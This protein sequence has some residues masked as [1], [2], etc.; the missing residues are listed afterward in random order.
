MPSLKWLKLKFIYSFFFFFFFFQKKAETIRDLQER[1]QQQQEQT[2]RLSTGRRSLSSSS[3]SVHS[4]DGIQRELELLRGEKDRQD[5]ET[6]I[7]QRSLEELSSRLEAQQQAI[8]AKDETI[9]QLMEMIQSNKGLESKQLEMH[10]EQHNADKKKLAE[11]LNQ[12]VK[13]REEIDERDRAISSL[14]EVMVHVLKNLLIINWSFVSSFLS[15][16]FHDSVTQCDQT[17][18]CT[19]WRKSSALKSWGCGFVLR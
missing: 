7:L 15:L 10:K 16:L 17:D 3:H 4:Q 5:N 8:Q 1:L 9:T 14:R 6:F 2:D 13:L 18:T 12:L 19:Q 11:A